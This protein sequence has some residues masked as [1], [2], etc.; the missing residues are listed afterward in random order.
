MPACTV[1]P[2]SSL[3]PNSKGESCNTTSRTEGFF[4]SSTA[5]ANKKC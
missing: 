2:C 5:S 3:V 1:A 4:K